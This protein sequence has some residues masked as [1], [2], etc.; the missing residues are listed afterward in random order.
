MICLK[1]INRLYL[2]DIADQS[3]DLLLE[4]GELAVELFIRGHQALLDA[5]VNELEAETQCNQGPRL[6]KSCHGNKYSMG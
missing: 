2:F 6:E 1:L 5:K 3:S 4:D